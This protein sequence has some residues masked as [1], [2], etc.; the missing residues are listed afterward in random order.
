MPKLQL[1]RFLFLIIPALLLFF[2]Y[3]CA[4]T[5]GALDA[6]WWTDNPP[7]P[8]AFEYQG[9]RRTSQYVTM[10]DGVKIAVDVYLPENM[11]DG[12]RLPAILSQTRYWRNIDLRWPV[13]AFISLPEEIERIVE[14]GYALVRLDARGSGASFGDR[15][16]PWSQDEVRDGHEIVDWIIRQPWSNGK[17]GSAGGSY[18]G[19]TAEFL[20]TTRHPAVLAIAPMFSLFDVYTDV[21]FPGGIHLSWFTEIW[22]RG[23]RAMDLNRPQDAL[24]WAPLATRGVMPVDADPG[25][26]LLRQAVRMHEKNY[27]VHDEARQ[28]EFRDDVSS[29]GLSMDRF[30]PHAFI[31]QLRQAGKPI[32]SNSGWF[33]GGY[34]HAAIKRWLTVRNPG[35]RLVLGAWDHGGDD[36]FRPFESP[37]PTQFDHIG[38]LLRFFDFYLKNKDTGIAQDPPVHYYTMVEDAWKSADTW[39]PPAKPTPYYLGASRTLAPVMPGNEASF[40]EYKVD[41]TA[42]TGDRA[43]WNA[44]AVEIAVNYPD[45]AREDKKLLC[46]TSA[47][48]ENDVEVT[49]HPLVALFMSSDTPDGEVFVYLE[50]VDELGRISYV[51]EG[52]LRIVHRQLSDQPPPYRT[53]TPFRTFLRRDAQPLRPGEIAEITFDLH[54]VSYL[55]SQGHGIRIAIAGADADHFRVLPGRPPTYRIHRGEKY[56]SRIILPVVEN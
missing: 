47:P 9:L 43:R 22:Q 44:L 2:I 10:R 46:Y 33:D 21:A 52:M 18:E 1:D 48:L 35:S 20:L 8:V 31:E 29:G 23:T 38:E 39:P 41:L 13:S 34:A 25:R 12:D 6:G 17:V 53:P 50:D 5:T 36:H 40:D 24:W 19:T 16:S 28:L 27:L 26:V 15:Q 11:P 51:T 37:V 56:P 55:F 7:A 3:G 49:G 45:R 54:P 14:S 42:G 30:S 4:A 32:Y